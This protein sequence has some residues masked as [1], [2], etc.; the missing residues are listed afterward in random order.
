MQRSDKMVITNNIR[1]FNPSHLIRINTTQF[2]PLIVYE[3]LSLMGILDESQPGRI[4]WTFPWTQLGFTAPRQMSQTIFFELEI[5][6]NL[7]Q[8]I[9][10]GVPGNFDSF[11]GFSTMM[12]IVLKVES[13][14]LLCAH[15][16][17]DKS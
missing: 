5:F 11:K 2:D 8:K 1:C 14:D 4:N 3:H 16:L 15:M 9:D 6:L 7:K 13:F 10:V 17:A 12:M